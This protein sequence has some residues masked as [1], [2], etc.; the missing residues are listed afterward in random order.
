L[1]R[2]DGHGSG[3]I[4]GKDHLQSIVVPGDPTEELLY[5]AGR[6]RRI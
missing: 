4:Q 6:S 3:E 2:S 5:K 1:R